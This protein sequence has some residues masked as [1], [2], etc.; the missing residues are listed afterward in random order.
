MDADTPGVHTYRVELDSDDHF[1][2]DDE[3]NNEASITVTV[4]LI[5][6]PG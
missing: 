4:A 2:E 6:D 3:S 1:D 5:V